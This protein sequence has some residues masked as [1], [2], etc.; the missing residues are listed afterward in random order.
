MAMHGRAMTWEWLEQASITEKTIL[1][2][3]QKDMED[4]KTRRFN[5][6]TLQ[7]SH[8]TESQIDSEQA[9]STDWQKGMRRLPTGVSTLHMGQREKKLSY[10]Y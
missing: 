3:M 10:N 4:N 6:E 7:D 9:N 1:M 2:A 8:L 5:Q